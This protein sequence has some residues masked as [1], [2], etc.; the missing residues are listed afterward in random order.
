MKN[1]GRPSFW[2]YFGEFTLLDLPLK[3]YL[4]TGKNDQVIELTFEWDG[5]DEIAEQF[6]ELASLIKGNE[7]GDIPV[8]DTGGLFPYAYT[9][10][11]KFVLEI[12][13]ELHTFASLKGRNPEEL[14]CRCFGVYR[15]DIHQLI[16]SG[17][18]I[19]SI[20]DLGDHL[21]AGIGCGSCHHD[22]KEEL[23]PL[24]SAPVLEEEAVPVMGLWEKLDP[25]GLARECH[26]ILRE[27]NSDHGA[28]QEVSLKGSRPGSVLV[29]I[30]G[31]GKWT[32]EN[33]GK[34]LQEYLDKGLGEGLSLIIIS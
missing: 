5:P 10:Y 22:L 20:R 25:Q 3:F 8:F 19:Q 30:K 34:S 9:F 13:D 28:G 2:R 6:S 15:A 29:S 27:W 33:I 14:I 7:L 11:R 17:A 18:E 4:D 12:K 24:L 21:Q 32:K 31:E 26:S 16:G 1:R 23:T